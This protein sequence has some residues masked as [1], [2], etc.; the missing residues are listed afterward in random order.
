MCICNDQLPADPCCTYAS[1]EYPS[2]MFAA[3]FY[4][5]PESFLTW[6]KWNKKL[7]VDWNSM[8]IFPSEHQRLSCL[9]QAVPSGCFQ[10]AMVHLCWLL[11]SFLASASKA[12]QSWEKFLMPI[13][14]KW[15]GI[16]SKQ[17]QAVHVTDLFAFLKRGLSLVWDEFSLGFSLKYFKMPNW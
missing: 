8:H 9:K 17:S 2:I 15:S 1:L 16:H 14:T 4:C 11:D 12:S 5:A 3:L 6:I 10:L 7:C 13:L